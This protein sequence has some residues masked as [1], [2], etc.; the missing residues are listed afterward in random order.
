MAP[1]PSTRCFRVIISDTSAALRPRPLGVFSRACPETR[2][3][4]RKSLRDAERL[5]LPASPDSSASVTRCWSIRSLCANYDSPRHCC[6]STLRRRRPGLLADAEPKDG[7]GS[8]PRAVER[9]QVAP[10]EARGRE[11]SN[12]VAEQDRQDVHQ[13]LVHEPSPQALAG[14]VGTEDFEVLAA[15]GVQR[16]GDGFPDITGE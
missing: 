15:R 9:F 1:A 3:P 12:A 4:R 7:D 6:Q 8:R 10:V 14:H 13:D 16:G 11:E 5:S 2:K